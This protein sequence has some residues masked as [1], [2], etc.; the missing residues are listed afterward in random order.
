MLESG[1]NV[2]P[3]E[4]ENLIEANMDFANEIVVYQAEFVSGR[5]SCQVICAGIYI[6]DETVRADRDAIK[7]CIEKI[8]GLLPDY[9]NIEYVELPETEYEKTSTR[10]IKRSTLP[11]KCSGEGIITM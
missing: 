9:K 1:K 11:E 2:C 5:S 6:S 8:N 7:A 4:V 3:E 10:K